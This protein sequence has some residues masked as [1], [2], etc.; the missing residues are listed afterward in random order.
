MTDPANAAQA[1]FWEERSSSWLDG[2]HHGALVTDPFGHQAMDQLALRPGERVLDIGCGGG[3]TTLELARRV[4]P[5]GWATGADIA[6]S[7]VAAAARRAQAAAVANIEFVTA[8]AQTAEL[9]QGTYDAVFSQ[10]GVMFFADPQAAFSRIR[11]ALRPRG[12]LAFT[13]WQA[14]SLNEWN[15]LPGA[16]VVAVTGQVPPRPTPG[17]PGPFSLAEPG[18]AADLLDRS[19]WAEVVVRP[20]A[21]TLVLA[22]PDAAS[23]TSL[24]Q[25]V[26]PVRE[27]LRQA[28]DDTRRRLVE[29][30]TEA[31]RTRITDGELRLGSAA[32]VVSATA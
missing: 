32:F 3:S 9:G 17:Q 8:D 20:V 13:C 26:G 11:R 18:R 15:A 4:A 23:M 14:L 22:A 27:A 28:D 31:L 24:A 25:W 21:R 12:R 29:A 1:A 6:A 19:G 30:V 10:F 16:A 5:D 2:E 7:M